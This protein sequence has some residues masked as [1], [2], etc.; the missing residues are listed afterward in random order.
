MADELPPGAWLPGFGQKVA[1]QDRRRVGVLRMEGHQPAQAPDGVGL[2]PVERPHQG[3]PLPGVAG[4]EGRAHVPAQVADDEIGGG[5][6][7]GQLGFQLRQG[8]AHHHRIGLFQRLDHLRHGTEDAALLQAQVRFPGMAEAA[9][10]GEGLAARADV[11]EVIMGPLQAPAG[12]GGLWVL[13]AIG[14]GGT[15]VAHHW[16]DG[17]QLEPGLH[18]TAPGVP[19]RPAADGLQGRAPD[20][21]EGRCVDPVEG[22][23]VPGVEPFRVQDRGRKVQLPL[24]FVGEGAGH[25][26]AG[27]RIVAQ[28]PAE[29]LKVA[30]MPEVVL[31]QKGDQ[32]RRA[33]RETELPGLVGALAGMAVE[34][35]LGKGPDDGDRI[36]AG[37]VVDG[38]DLPG[39]QG[40]GQHRRQ[41]LT[42]PGR[43]VEQRDHDSD[44]RRGTD[45]GCHAGRGTK[46]PG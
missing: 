27:R 26:R 19:D 23:G 43:P 13:H 37:A 6:R 4:G 30:G 41:R 31:V 17:G 16:G 3:P 39:R 21:H 2:A 45:G 20:Q 36:V 25:C 22:K 34:G 40:L 42:D 8:G 11:E 28:Q 46:G 44:V 1:D 29:Q 10:A 15:G 35:H 33:A 24:V 5:D 18:V 12:A 7:T 38:D 14:G 32:G 9:L